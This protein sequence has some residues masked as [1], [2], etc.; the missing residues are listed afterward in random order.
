LRPDHDRPPARV[1]Q[2]VDRE[3]PALERA[4]AGRVDHDSD[5]AP[6]LDAAQE[7]LRYPEVD[8]E[9]LDLLEVHDVVPV[10]HVIAGADAAQASGRVEGRDQGLLAQPGP[11]E[12]QGRPRRVALRLGLVEGALRPGAV[13]D[14]RARPL[15]VGVGELEPGVRLL[16]LR[17]LDRIVEPDQR[18]PSGDRLALGEVEVHDPAADLGPQQDRL[19]GEERA[20][21][22]DR[23]FGRADADLRRLDR[24]RHPRARPAAPATGA[25]LLLG[26][27][28]DELPVGTGTRG[29]EQQDD[30]HGDQ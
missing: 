30:Q 6:D 20:D 10:G 18:L 24:H 26:R 12:L 16:Q 4:V 11:G 7:D 19:V 22:L 29:A 21:R 15:V 25:P 17:L 23:D 9:R 13:G 3:D 1:D 5:R 2:R 14:E 8:L 27:D 28:Q